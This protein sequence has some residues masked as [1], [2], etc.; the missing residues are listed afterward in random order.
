MLSETQRI[1]STTIIGTTITAWHQLGN[2]SPMYESDISSASSGDIKTNQ[3]SDTAKDAS[4]YSEAL[5]DLPVTKYKRHGKEYWKCNLCK[6]E[7][8]C[9]NV[10]KVIIHLAQKKKKKSIGHCKFTCSTVTK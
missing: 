10:T 9:W 3:K 5:K 7:F 6:K 8:S 2:L 4:E 1:T